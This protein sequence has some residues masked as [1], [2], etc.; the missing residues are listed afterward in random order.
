M[1]SSDSRLCCCNSYLTTYLPTASPVKWMM[2]LL[3][4]YNTKIGKR[5]KKLKENVRKKIVCVRERRQMRGEKG[6]GLARPYSPNHVSQVSHALH[7]LHQEH[8]RNMHNSLPLVHKTNKTSFTHTLLSLSLPLV[9]NMY[10]QASISLT[11]RDVRNPS[12]S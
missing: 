7:Q 5:E 1:F 3:P 8:N 9:H 6:P 2:Y 10:V 12:F 11:Q 4:T